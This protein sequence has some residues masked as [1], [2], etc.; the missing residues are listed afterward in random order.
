MALADQ[1]AGHPL[2]LINP[3]LYRL[4]GHARP[5]PG[6]RHLGQQHRLLLPGHG[7]Q[8]AT[9]HRLPG[10]QGLRPGNRRRHGQRQQVRLRAGRGPG[11]LGPLAS[12]D[13]TRLARPSGRCSRRSPPARPASTSGTRDTVA[14]VHGRHLAERP[15]LVGHPADEVMVVLP[16]QPSVVPTTAR[17]LLGHLGR[18]DRDVGPAGL[19]GQLAAGGRVEVLVVLDP[20]ARRGPVPPLGGG[21]S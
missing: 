18:R 11:A 17:R 12:A 14:D 10:R 5:R 4:L 8:A 19:L 13:R 21:S 6:R 15:P 1:V 2:G 16:D 3:T 7:G 9:G 20:A